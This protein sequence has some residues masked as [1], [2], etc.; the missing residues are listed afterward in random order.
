[1]QRLQD[2]SV[3]ALEQLYDRH[4]RTALAVAYRVLGD[5]NLAE[6]A[7]QESFVAVW[8]RP[9]LFKPDRGPFRP[10]FLSIVRHRAID[11]ARSRSSARDQLSLEQIASEPFYPGPWPEVRIK[12]DIARV[13]EAMRELPQEQAEAITLAY[14]GGYTQKEVSE[15]VGVPLG[16]VKGRIRLGMQRLRG[17][18]IESPRRPSH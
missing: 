8:R 3:T 5:G 7:I 12:L 13:K 16:T 4:H 1:M 2:R 17:I 9:D 6:D 10:W 18:L 11:V 15:K 14:Y